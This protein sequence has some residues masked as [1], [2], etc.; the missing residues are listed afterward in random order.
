MIDTGENPRSAASVPVASG[1][2][3]GWAEVS[4]GNSHTCARR[5]DSSLWCWGDNSYGQVGD[6]STTDRVVPVRTGTRSDW[7]HV[8]AGYTHTCGIRTN[9]TL[10]CWGDNSFGQLGIGI[11]LGQASPVQVGTANTWRDVSVGVHSTCALQHGGALFCWGDNN[12]GQVGDG[13]TGVAKRTP[14]RIGP[15]IIWDDVDVGH[16]FACAADVNRTLY[17]WG[18]NEAGRL[19]NG[20]TV[21]SATPTPVATAAHWSLF[22]AGD[23]HVLGVVGSP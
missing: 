21:H 5:N 12:I 4:A 20:T 7:S 10:W 13:T 15:A 18:S 17:C 2:I 14:T 9:G 23:D 16:S 1:S 22:A 6:G 8:S 11:F 19:A 3:A